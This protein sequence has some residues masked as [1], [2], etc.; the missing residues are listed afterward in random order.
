MLT[1]SR[2]SWQLI[3]YLSK[4]IRR[5][6]NDWR[7]L[8]WR[9]AKKWRKI[10]ND[11]QK[12]ADGRISSSRYRK[13]EIAKYEKEYFVRIVDGSATE[14]DLTSALENLSKMLTEHYGKAPV[15]IIDEYD[16][17][18]Q[19]GYAK[20][21][22]IWQSI[23]WWMRRTIVSLD[24][25]IQKYRRWWNTMTFLIKKRSWR[26]GMMVISLVVRRYIIH[27]QWLTIFRKDVFHR[28]TG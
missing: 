2:W 16:T 12:P 5:L 22:I 8:G 25:P 1:A 10:P 20:D 26:N 24:S 4:K 6:K 11:A 14:V 21:L 27:G 7:W 13:K 9:P 18:I 19:E 23:P 28:P 17:P 3:G 15:I